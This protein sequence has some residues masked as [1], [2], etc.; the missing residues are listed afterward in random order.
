MLATMKTKVRSQRRLLPLLTE[1]SPLRCNCP[2]PAAIIA[3]VNRVIAFEMQLGPFAVAQLRIL[4]EI[5]DLTGVTPP[6]PPRMFVADTLSDPYGEPG[7]FPP[8]SRQ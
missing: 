4:A 3:A 6:P 1:S 5:A 2:V 8:Y 7:G